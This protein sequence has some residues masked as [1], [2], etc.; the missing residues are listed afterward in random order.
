MLYR[1][2]KVH[3]VTLGKQFVVLM[4]GVL[5][6]DLAVMGRIENCQLHF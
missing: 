6:G 2:L 4:D 3:F 5:C 1:A